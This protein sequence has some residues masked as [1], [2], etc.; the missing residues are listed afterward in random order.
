MANFVTVSLECRS[1]EVRS[2]FKT[3]LAHHRE[4]VPKPTR[5][6]GMPDMLVLEL[7]EY[8]PTRTLSEVRSMMHASP[9]T[10]VI[11][12]SKRT[13]P[14]IMLEAM[15]MGVKEF[16]PEPLESKDIE[17]ALVRFKTRFAAQNQDAAMNLGAVLAII[18]SK[19]GVGASVAA[20]NLAIALQQSAKEGTNTVLI[21]LNLS[22]NDLSL[23]L[24]VVA[25]RGWHDLSQ[26]IS[27]LDP[28]MLQG[29]LVKHTSGVHLLG[30]GGDGSEESLSPGCVLYT[31][32]LLRSMFDYV[33]VDCGARITPQVEECLELS[34]QVYMITNL[35]IPSIRHSSRILQAIQDRTGGSVPT[36][37]VINRYRSRDAEMLKQAEDLLRMKSDWL[38][39]NDYGPVSQSLDEGKSVLQQNPKAEISQSYSKRAAEVV[40]EQ[41]QKRKGSH[42]I[43]GP[44]NYES[45]L[46]RL[47]TGMTNGV[48]VKTK[49]A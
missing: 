39:P 6:T 16:L 2:A 33:V 18:G 24:D 36:S 15:R 17:E 21:D 22:S 20:L 42:G 8:N 4:F 29:I 27:R 34:N 46:G 44:E 35:S 32:D 1:E 25:Q 38:I 31:I 10:E 5:A 47:W 28:A 48:R 40:R 14:Q 3:A 41:T 7:D 9:R 12:T 37:L 11:L 19:A 49:T 30:A 23:Y 43:P 45:L 13:D 26:D